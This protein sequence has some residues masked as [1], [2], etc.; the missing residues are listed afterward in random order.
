MITYPYEVFVTIPI[1]HGLTAAADRPWAMGMVG[2]LGTFKFLR[3]LIN[4]WMRHL[5]RT[6]LFRL[7]EGDPMLY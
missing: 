4:Y 5:I 3:S 2:R 6:N 7:P 1:A